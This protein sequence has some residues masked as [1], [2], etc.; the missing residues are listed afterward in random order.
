MILPPVPASPVVLALLL[1]LAPAG[2]GAQQPVSSRQV[3]HADSLRS[4]PRY[5]DTVRIVGRVIVPPGVLDTTGRR[6]FVQD[7]AGAVFV[8]RRRDQRDILIRKGDSVVVTGVLEPNRDFN[9]V[10]GAA[11]TVVPGA[12]ALPAPLPVSA[13]IRPA[14]DAAEARLVVLEGVVGRALLGRGDR[15][16]LLSTAGGDTTYSVAIVEEDEGSHSLALDRFAA[17]DRVRVIGAMS[18]RTSRN[19]VHV[20][21]TV[22]ATDAGNVQAIGMTVAR[23]GLIFWSMTALAIVGALVVALVRFRGIAASTRMRLDRSREEEAERYRSM[24]QDAPAGIVVYRDG[25]IIFANPAFARM[26]GAPSADT[27]Q[28][29]PI[30]SVVHPDER[31]DS[32]K[33]QEHLRETTTAATTMRRMLRMDGTVLDADVISSR[34]SFAGEEAIQAVVHDVGE[35][36]SAARALEASEIRFRLASRATNDVI[37]DHDLRDQSLAWGDALGSVFGHDPAALSTAAGWLGQIHPEDLERVTATLHAA[38]RDGADA[39]Q[40]EYRFRRRDGTYASV[41]DRGYI[42]H[43]EAGQVVRMVGAMQDVSERIELESRLRQ[44][45]KMEAVGQLAAGIAHDFNNLLTVISTY[46][47]LALQGVAEKT[48]PRSDIEEIQRASARAA[49]LTRQL[50]AFSR[51]QVVKPEPLDLNVVVQET[52]QLLRRTISAHITVQMSL[53]HQACTIL[54][55]RGQMEQVIMNLMLNAR[56]AMREGGGT[57]TIETTCA[58][59]EHLPARARTT[60]SGASVLLTVRDDGKGMS[61]AEL[62]RIFEPFFT[63]KAP[64]EGTG[65]GLAMVYG[66]VTNA[67]GTVWAESTPGR[68]AA[69]HVALPAAVLPSAQPVSAAT[70]RDRSAVVATILLVED[71]EPVRTSLAR[72]LTRQRYVVMQAP[73]AADALTLWEQAGPQID[74]V[75]TDVVMPGMLGTEMVERL[76]QDRQD[77]PVLYISGYTN[78]AIDPAELESGRTGFVAKP[79]SLDTLS[80]ELR[81]LLRHGPAA[82]G[83]G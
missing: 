80:S 35:R 46:S 12:P 65:L 16:L 14:L 8:E 21:Y 74:V 56:D 52:V 36:R 29:A 11:I 73:N 18:R 9:E 70:Q 15:A 82:F 31:D 23:R 42:L 10:E 71:E 40:A 39:W 17:G 79:F 68:G 81:Q 44:A 60:A 47:E 67:G 45:Q 34:V 69:F 6:L 83:R 41:F 77:L 5:G 66:A 30:L 27:L 4:R 24:I 50:L 7:S 38:W 37:W 25:R 2:A 51:R 3:R 75:V 1:L 32:T 49:N 62:A 53:C 72:T 54:G 28:G 55:D 61:S 26:V 59:A 57:I 64:G 43:D 76:R 48:D 22:H 63:T 33:I 19:R 58:S 78:Q 13:L 20:R